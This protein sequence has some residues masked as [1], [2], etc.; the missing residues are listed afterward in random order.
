MAMVGSI[1]EHMVY[2]LS[3]PNTD[4]EQDRNSVRTE[5]TERHDNNNAEA[6]NNLWN[7]QI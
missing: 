1:Q 5:G 4:K 6:G 7:R 2:T 3:I